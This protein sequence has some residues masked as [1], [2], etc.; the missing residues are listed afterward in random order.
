MN[1][2][3]AFTNKALISGKLVNGKVQIPVV[4]YPPEQV[5]IS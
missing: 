3:E 4:V 5:H 2:I 1:E